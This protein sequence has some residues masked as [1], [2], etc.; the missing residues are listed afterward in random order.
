MLH[1]CGEGSQ[2]LALERRVHD[3]EPD[4]PGV[5]AEG[6]VVEVVIARAPGLEL[7]DAADL[8]LAFVKGAPVAGRLPDGGKLDEGVPGVGLRNERLDALGDVRRD[9]GFRRIDDLVGVRLVVGQCLGD[10]VMRD[11]DADGPARG[12]VAIGVLVGAASVHRLDVSVRPVRTALLVDE[13]DDLA[14]GAV[15]VHADEELE[16]AP[17]SADVRGGREVAP[18]DDLPGPVP[19]LAV[20][21]EVGPAFDFL[22]GADGIGAIPEGEVGRLDGLL[23]IGEDRVDVRGDLIGGLLDAGSGDVLAIV[24]GP[25]VD[26]G[27]PALDARKI[28]AVPVPAHEAEGE[29]PVLLHE[30]DEIVVPVARGAREIVGGALFDAVRVKGPHAGDDVPFVDDRGLAPGVG[31]REDLRHRLGDLG[32]EVRHAGVVADGLGDRV[33]RDLDPDGAARGLVA[34]D[35]LVGAPA[36]HGVDVIVRPVRAALVVGEGDDLGDGAVRLDADEELE[37]A[38]LSADV[39]RVRE[40]APSERLAGLVL[41]LAVGDD[42][43]IIAAEGDFLADR[44]GV[45]E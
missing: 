14:N 37:V 3:L 23:L 1:P 36:V 2:V 26:L 27:D 8:G 7:V 17:P 45:P 19:H 31:L 18:P 22:G 33:M 9:D 12:L 5:L 28:G 4:D 35:V 32:R 43:L 15:G 29:A 25:V 34:E 10:R 24:G 39:R 6:D 16:V 20:G 21:V 38:P 13:G 11:P 41:H 30:D 44:R 40:V 42:V